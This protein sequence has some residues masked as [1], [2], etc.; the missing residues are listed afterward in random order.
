MPSSLVASRSKER[1]PEL[2]K[3]RVDRTGIG[4]LPVSRVE[5]SDHLTVL[6]GDQG[7][8]VAMIREERAVEPFD[9]QRSPEPDRA[10][11]VSDGSDVDKR[12]LG[13]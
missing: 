6:Q 10:R 11:S 9:G 1:A 4:L 13:R 7:P 3:D 12:N 2:S 8:G 5:E